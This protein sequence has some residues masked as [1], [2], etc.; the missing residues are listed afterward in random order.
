MKKIYII[1]GLI[2]SLFLF[3]CSL[4]SLIVQDDTNQDINTGTNIE[5]IETTES[6]STMFY[7]NKEEVF[8]FEF[9]SGRTFDENKYWFKTIVFSPL[10][11]KIKENVGITTQQLQKFLSVQEYYE[12]TINNLQNTI[13]GFKETSAVDIVQWELKGK[14]ITYEYQEWDVMIES[15]ETFLMAPENK[16]YIINYTAT[17]DTFD[18]FI[19]WANS[20]IKSFKIK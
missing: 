13:K 2:L 8:S 7:E 15:Q 1:S 6:I 11:D 16:V 18:K 12:E 17:K 9:L 19:D 4:D 14:T 3:W 20:I 5:E 10:D